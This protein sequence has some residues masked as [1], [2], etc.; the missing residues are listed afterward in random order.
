MATVRDVQ[1]IIHR[2]AR[3]V[4]APRFSLMSLREYIPSF[5]R[6]YQEDHPELE[7]LLGPESQGLLLGHLEQLEQAGVIE[8]T[9]DP[10][11]SLPSSIYYSAFYTAEIQRWYTRMNDDRTLSFPAEEDIPVAIPSHIVQTVAVA[12]NLMHWIESE[13]EEPGQ[14]LRLRFPDGINPLI[15]TVRSLR[16]QMLPLVLAKI[17]DY[18]RSDN[19]ASF[20]ETKLRAIFRNR[21]MLVRDEIETAQIRPNEALQSILKPNDFQFHFWTQMSSMIIKEYA[22]KGE[23]LD[24]EHAFCQAAYLLGYYVV[25]HKTRI[26]KDLQREEARKVLRKHL[27]KPPYVFELHDLYMLTDDR[28]VLLTKKI[29]RSD[30]ETWIEEMLKRP[31]EQDIS[32]LVSIDTPEKKGLILHSAQYVPLLL[33]LVQS[34][35]PV[36]RRSLTHRML[37]ELQNDQSEDWHKDDAA[38]EF[39]LLEQVRQEFPLLYGLASFKT[40]FLVVDGQELPHHEKTSAMA[41]ID[42][43]KHS[44]RSWSSILG[45]T[46]EEVYRDARIQLPFWMVIPVLGSIIRLFRAM[47]SSTDHRKR[48]KETNQKKKAPPRPSSGRGRKQHF[49]AHIAELQSRYLSPGQTPQERLDQLRQSWNPLID[50]RAHENLVQDVNTLCRDVLRRRRYDRSLQPPT[51]E[52]IKD[53]AEKIAASSSF[54]RIKRRKELETYLELYMLTLLG[55]V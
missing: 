29:A 23:K 41:M 47:F 2:Y 43:S 31:S 36:L 40:L 42:R 35:T 34:A 3:H 28:G 13:G 38:F 16:E 12:E 9:R 21:E 22:Q 45:I 50:P 30:I 8:L 33:R 19:A 48:Q 7:L 5:V 44:L 11:S 25:H 20:M 54:E 15:T 37:S 55:K 49:Q 51:P 10:V 46:R 39:E 26:Q 53:L 18:L 27:Q 52:H 24:R 6:R 17:R 1:K 4:R 32:E 14:I